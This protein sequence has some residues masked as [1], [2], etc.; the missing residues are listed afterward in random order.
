M[1]RLWMMFITACIVF[2]INSFAVD[3]ENAADLLDIE[4]KRKEEI[5]T[6]VRVSA[7]FIGKAADEKEMGYYLNLHLKNALEFIRGEDAERV[8]KG[9]YRKSEMEKDRIIRESNEELLFKVALNGK[10]ARARVAAVILCFF[11]TE[12][13]QGTISK[14]TFLE[15]DELIDRLKLGERR[16]V[17]IK[18][19]AVVWKRVDHFKDTE[20]MSEAIKSHGLS[21]E[22]DI[23]M[24]TNPSEDFLKNFIRVRQ[25]I[26]FSNSVVGNLALENYSFALARFD[27]LDDF[28]VTD[29]EMAAKLKAK[30]YESF[31]RKFEIAKMTGQIMDVLQKQSEASA[32]EESSLSS[33]PES[34]SDRK[35]RR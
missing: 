1:K 8:K 27:Y 7:E 3:S 17:L 9:A 24:F 6:L 15:V 33:P 11:R 4:W 21:I 5:S 12:F 10:Y 28:G 2:S 19:D 22:E 23:R 32:V 34:L 25:N 29:F 26:L 14:E 30:V 35:R 20:E 13:G 31:W 16:V 18:N